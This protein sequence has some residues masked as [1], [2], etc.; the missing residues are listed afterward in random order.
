MLDKDN[1]ISASVSEVVMKIPTDE[2][3]PMFFTLHC[4]SIQRADQYIANTWKKL[5]IRMHP[6][7]CS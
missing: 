1:T 3:I 2:G 4:H 5:F 7:Q 6:I